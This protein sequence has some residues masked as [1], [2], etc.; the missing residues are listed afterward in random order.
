MIVLIQIYN[1]FVLKNN[2]K[3]AVT[4]LVLFGLFLCP[5]RGGVI[6]PRIDCNG[7]Y[8][9][10]H[11]VF[12]SGSGYTTF[13]FPTINKTEGM[14]N[15]QKVDRANT[16]RQ[17]QAIKERNQKIINEIFSAAG[18]GDFIESIMECYQAFHD[19]ED[20]WELNPRWREDVLFDIRR[21]C[22][23]VAKLEQTE[24]EVKSEY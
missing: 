10:L 5:A 23:F 15:T 22:V 21:I 3:G 9:P 19:R 11:G 1:M 17:A 2:V 14:K 20:F 8:S 24:E 13:L 6:Q 7:L 4:L 18:A 16:V 12:F